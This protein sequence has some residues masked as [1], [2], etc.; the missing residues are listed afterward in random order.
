M[1]SLQA[2]LHLPRGE[3]PGFSIRTNG[4]LATL[5]SGSDTEPVAYNC[6]GVVLQDHRI[7]LGQHI[8][9]TLATGATCSCVYLA[10]SLHV[11]GLPVPEVL[12]G[13]LEE[14]CQQLQSHIPAGTRHLSLQIAC[15]T[16]RHDS[17]ACGSNSFSF[18]ADGNQHEQ[19]K[20][21]LRAVCLQQHGSQGVS[22]DYMCTWHDSF[23][24]RPHQCMHALAQLVEH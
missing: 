1:P 19:E 3:T 4:S 23:Y 18:R 7:C 15:H 22:L 2:F 13:L 6:D 11:K 5:R 14:A 24:Y 9:S 21:G 16:L 12:Q 20:V 10:S 8:A 17:R